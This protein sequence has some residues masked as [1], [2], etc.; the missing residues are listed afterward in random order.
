MDKQHQFDT[1]IEAYFTGTLSPDDKKAF[2]ESLENDKAL[3]E[4]FK[5]Y[6]LFDKAVQVVGEYELQL[7]AQRMATETGPL[8]IP[9]F[10]FWERMWLFFTHKPTSESKWFKLPQWRIAFAGVSTTV[11]C[12]ILYANVFVSSYK[13]ISTSMINNAESV[14][15]KGDNAKTVFSES[16][17]LYNTGKLEDLQKM[18]QDPNQVIAAAAS[19]Y[20]AHLYLKNKNF[21]AAIAAFD[22][23][24]RLDNLTILKSEINPNICTIRINRFLAILGKTKK[25]EEINSMIDVLLSQSDCQTEKAKVQLESIRKEINNPWQLLKFNN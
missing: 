19:Y 24:L 4:A 16:E 25:K 1:Q 2:E 21:D 11:A 3:Q 17:K 22:T 10:N 13:D 20:L 9:K 23:T 18:A 5:P 6:K 8:P 15:T 14:G 12:C 7:T